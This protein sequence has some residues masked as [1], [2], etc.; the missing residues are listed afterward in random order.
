MKLTK[1]INIDV[2][3]VKAEY[4]VKVE[5]APFIAILQLA[6]EHEVITPELLKEELLHPLS[7]AACKNILSRLERMGYLEEHSLEISILSGY[8]TIK[9]QM[10]LT[11]LGKYAAEKEEY[12]QQRMGLIEIHVAENNE[13]ISDRIVKMVEVREENFDSKKLMNFPS[14]L[15]DLANGKIIPLR[16]KSI[17]I[18][19][20]EK[21]CF[22]KIKNKAELSLSIENSKIIVKVEDYEKVIDTTEEE[23][24]NEILEN[25][26]KKKFDTKLQAVKVKFDSGN[27]L[28]KR[29]VSIKKPL[30]QNTI[31]DA[32]ELKNV[33]FTPATSQDAY[34]WY[35]ELVKIRIGK[36]FLNDQ[37]FENF[38]TEIANLFLNHSTDLKGTLSRS[39]MISILS[40]KNDFYTKSKLETID[41]LNY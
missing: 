15:S 39:K 27:L 23:C 5:N 20:V 35:F 1:K 7:K 22:L 6:Q 14:E 28:F 10:T 26:F 9:N 19:E 3:Q 37:E 33:E 36:Y 30:F 8:N 25:E 32:F 29:K 40:D 12:Y 16:S 24:R 34:D 17:G 38:S 31:F 2:Y 41:Y 13:F 11:E 4:K 18:D 21:K